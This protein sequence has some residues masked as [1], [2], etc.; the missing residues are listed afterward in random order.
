MN[1]FRAGFLASVTIL[2]AT[3]HSIAVAQEPSKTLPNPPLPRKSLPVVGRVVRSFDAKGI[4]VVILRAGDAEQA[5]VKT[6]AGRRWITI[7]GIPEGGAQGYHSPDPNWRE[8]PASNWGLDFKAK[9]F[10]PKLVVSTE[11]EISYIHHY[12]HLANVTIVVPEGVKVVKENR[13]LNGES[14]RPAE[15]SP[16]VEP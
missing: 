5:E 3:H 10:G 9:A 11:N 7:S 2:L 16:P 15:L 4:Q 1:R 12:Y 14:L 6:V 13:K 8:T